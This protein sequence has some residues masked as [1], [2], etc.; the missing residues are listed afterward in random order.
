[1]T[2]EASR[3][4]AMGKAFAGHETVNHASDEYVRKGAA[5]IIT[6]TVEAYISVF[7]RSFKGA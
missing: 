3:Y 4:V 1:M 5:T 6:N 7:K 2:D